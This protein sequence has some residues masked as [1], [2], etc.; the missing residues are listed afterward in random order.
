MTSILNRIILVAILFTSYVFGANFRYAEQEV[1]EPNLQYV[2][3]IPRPS[4]FARIEREFRIPKK[5]FTKMDQRYEISKKK[6]R[7]HEDELNLKDFENFDDV[8]NFIKINTPDNIPKNSQEETS[9]MTE[10]STPVETTLEKYRSFPPNPEFVTSRNFQ[11]PVIKENS[12]SLTKDEEGF[13]TKINTVIRNQFK[14]I[15][16]PFKSSSN[17]SESSSRNFGFNGFDKYFTRFGTVERVQ[18]KPKKDKRF[19]NI[20]TIL[21]FENSRCQAQ[22]TFLSYEGTCYHRSECVA[23]GG[24]SMGACAKGYGVCCVC[25]YVFNFILNLTKVLNV[26]CWEL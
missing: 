20:F 26:L 1:D 17:S 9:N 4:R 23:L 18:D 16:N 11:K 10:I 25:K 6:D 24:Y 7:K 5:N 19:L 22:G 2:E 3:L 15:F 21:Q 14:K 13:L 12:K 8:K